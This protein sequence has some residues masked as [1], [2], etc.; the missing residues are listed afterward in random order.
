MYPI[1]PGFCLF[2]PIVKFHLNSKNYE[3]HRNFADCRS[4]AHV[5][6]DVDDEPYLWRDHSWSNSTDFAPN[7][8]AMQLWNVGQR[9]GGRHCNLGFAGHS[10]KRKE[11]V[12]SYQ[13][14]RREGWLSAL[15]P[16]H[17]AQVLGGKDV[18][19]HQRQ[20]KSEKWV[21]KSNL[22]Q[23]GI[24]IKFPSFPFFCMCFPSF[25]V[26]SFL[27]LDHCRRTAAIIPLARPNAGRIGISKRRV[28][29]QTWP[30]CVPWRFF[31]FAFGTG[32]WCR[33]CKPGCPSTCKF[34]D[35]FHCVISNFLD[36]WVSNHGLQRCYD[37]GNCKH[38]LKDKAVTFSQQV[39]ELLPSPPNT[40]EA[41]LHSTWELRSKFLLAH[42]LDEPLRLLAWRQDFFRAHWLVCNVARFLR[43]S[44]FPAAQDD[45]ADDNEAIESS[46]GSLLLMMFLCYWKFF[47]FE[48]ICCLFRN[49]W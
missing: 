28:L 1:R 24:F 15:P 32:C 40:P 47:V 9:E 31:V 36:F 25:L 4:C 14:L 7:K 45:L 41:Q 23:G 29:R 35:C 48:F 2:C 11:E 5:P 34:A 38:F 13:A 12:N 44:F 30:S 10:D 3:K 42:R 49:L 22:G 43:W 19:H 20:R 37:S 27:D 18:W 8:D 17:Q 33:R 39:R 21:G 6:S 16:G 26:F 46:H